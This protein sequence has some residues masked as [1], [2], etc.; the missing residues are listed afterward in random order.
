MTLPKTAS[1]KVV[2]GS[3]PEQMLQRE[4]QL[5]RS[6]NQKVEKGDLK[7]FQAI[8]EFLPSLKQ[9]ATNNEKLSQVY[10]YDLPDFMKK[11]ALTTEAFQQ[12]KQV[13]RESTELRITPESWLAGPLRQTHG[14]LWLG[15][16]DGEY[17]TAVIL[18]GVSPEWNP[19]ELVN[20]LE[21]VALIDKTKETS[22]LFG[23]YRVLMSWLLVVAYLLIGAVLAVRYGVA[24]AIRVLIPPVLSVLLTLSF[25]GLT[26]QAINL[27]HILALLM[28][29]GIGIDYTL[30]FRESK[31]DPRYT[32]LAITLSAITTLLSFGLL[33]LSNTA[34]ISGFGLTVLIG[35]AFSYLLAPFAMDEDPS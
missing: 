6:L 20:A 28:V 19:A 27:F 3:S 1:F 14:Y 5:V 24:G 31:G 26:N 7:S 9:Q 22:S 2:K 23:R 29:L 33:Y 25:L 13:F 15:K 4:E 12:A 8:T 35:I 34:A 16:I 18:G 32:F 30:F 17:F 11:L 10:E 21:G